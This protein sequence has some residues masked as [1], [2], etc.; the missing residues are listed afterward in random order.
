MGGMSW[1]AI[2]KLELPEPVSIRTGNPTVVNIGTKAEPKWRV[3]N[4]AQKRRGG[5][6][7]RDYSTARH[8]PRMRHGIDDQPRLSQV[9]RAIRRV[10]QS[11]QDGSES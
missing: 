4:R 2:K 9:F 10:H 3:Y 8:S 11:L 7:N 5:R 1:D 6:I